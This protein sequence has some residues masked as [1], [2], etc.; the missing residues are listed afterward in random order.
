MPAV[1]A[2]L[3]AG[4]VLGAVSGALSLI[5][6]KGDGKTAAK[7]NF[8]ANLVVTGLIVTWPV[9]GL[10]L[11]TAT[12]AGVLPLI[13]LDLTLAMV[14]A[15]LAD[16]FAEGL[17]AAAVIMALAVI[18]AGGTWLAVHNGP[19]NA[20]EAAH[21]VHVT[22]AADD[23][24]PAS[25]TSDLVVVTPDEAATRASQAMSSGI[26]ATRN[27]A[28]FTNLGPATLQR[29]DGKMWYV[30]QLEFDGAGN[31]ARLHAIVPGYIMI[32]A[33]DPNPDAA[34][35]ERYDGQ[36]KDSC[37]M[38]VSLA[39]GQGSEPMR[40]VRDHLAGAGQYTLQDPTLEIQDGTGDPYFTVT[41]LKPQLGT[42]FPAPVAVAV[43]NA[44]TGQVT[45]YDLPGH[46]PDQLAAHAPWV[47]RV[48]SQATAE[49]IVNWYGYYAQASWPGL[50]GSNANRFQ[51]SG[52]P[53]LTYTGDENPSWRMLL[54]SFNAETSVYRI[55]EMDSATGAM[56]IYAPASAMGI[57]STVASAFCNAQGVGAGNVRSNHLIPEDMTLHVID[58][59][60]V[61]MTSYE[62]SQASGSST[63][64]PAQQEGDTDDPCGTGEAPV[65]NPTF[66]GIGFVPAYNATAASAVFG[67]T[68]EQALANLFTGIAQQ[69]SSNGANPGAGAAEITITGTICGKA[70]D[71][72]NGNTV[73]YV[74]LCGAGGKPD[75]TKVYT[76]TSAASSGGP[77]LVLAGTGDDVVIKV[78]RV[79]ASSS[80]QQ[81]QGFSDTQHP[82]TTPGG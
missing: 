24:L 56:T 4:L 64:S 80:Q 39:G 45:K 35:V 62:S 46:G 73:Y 74:T 37:T 29:V 17:S 75:S 50:G 59:Q 1:L 9:A 11:P 60:L 40:W 57:E 12:F 67:A 61:W 14:I 13:V 8:F 69:G 77:A 30:F 72:E 18:A 55:V 38:I 21:I 6:S 76:G 54:T 81:I 28:T 66:T 27:F 10:T 36:C 20:Q 53:V 49:Q 23:A 16:G 5:R 43:I 70:P 7:V 47:D 2:G 32:S 78:L 19:H 65:S 34:P 48:Y 71:T 15:A 33:E 58:G 3:I 44:H 82:V 31:K 42:T 63:D 51:V 41:M 79:S 22:V 26:A 25:V 52:D 68:R